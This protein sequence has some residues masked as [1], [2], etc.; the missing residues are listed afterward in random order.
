[1]DCLLNYSQK[2]SSEQVEDFVVFIIIPIEEGSSSIHSL[3]FERQQVYFILQDEPRSEK[4]K[5]TNQPTNQG[6]AA[7]Q[8]SRTDGI[9]FLAD[10]FGL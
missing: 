1:M 9:D 3:T 4:T 6:A 7:S 2:L 10:E 8:F 5:T